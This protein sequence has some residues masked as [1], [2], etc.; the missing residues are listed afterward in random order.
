MHPYFFSLLYRERLAEFER[1]AEIRRHLPKRES[2]RLP[3]FG[4][5]LTRF[6][7]HA[8]VVASAGAEARP[9]H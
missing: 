6:R 5:L 1:Q 7:R 3:R 2:R 8:P 4:S 9:C